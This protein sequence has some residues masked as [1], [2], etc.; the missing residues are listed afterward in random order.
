MGL[1][2]K[3]GGLVFAFLASAIGLVIWLGGVALLIYAATR[4]TVRYSA[5]GEPLLQG[6]SM[7]VVLR[8]GLIA[9]GALIALVA[10]VVLLRLTNRLVPFLICLAFGALAFVG[11]ATW[12]P[13]AQTYATENDAVAADAVAPPVSEDEASAP[14]PL[15]DAAPRPEAPPAAIAPADRDQARADIETGAAAPAPRSRSLQPPA[16][17]D[18]P[19]AAA[20]PPPAELAA[21]SGSGAAAP[22]TAA[23]AADAKPS[24]FQVAELK[25]NKPAEMQIDT[26]Y[27]VGATIAGALAETQATLGNVGPTVSRETKI[28]R[29]VRVEL[30]ASDF[31]VKKLHTVDTV[32][33]TPET[34]G[35]WS[36]EVIPKREGADRKMLL[37]VWGVLERDGVAQGDILIKTYEET[38]P[39][40]VT[41]IARVRLVSQGIIDRWQPLAGALGVIGGIWVFLQKLL[42]SLRPRRKEEPV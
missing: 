33:I 4:E 2:T 15:P 14:A 40:K 13:P 8:G 7:D 39:V 19:P 5:N 28:T 25:F 21:P 23:A 22:P 38:I 36:W 32:L 42:G 3:W 31:Q 11:G 37:Q 12:Q 18:E 30:V 27:V 1:L 9:I 34:S 17:A 6:L 26:P 20:P 16:A 35:Q 10:S 41:P 24:D 29:K